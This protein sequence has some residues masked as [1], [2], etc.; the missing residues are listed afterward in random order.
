[1]PSVYQLSCSYWL[2]NDSP[3]EERLAF[4]IESGDYFPYLASVIGLLK[5]AARTCNAIPEAHGAFIEDIQEDLLHLQERYDIVP[6]E[7]PLSY[8]RKKM[9]RF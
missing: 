3:R 7:T 1:M 2:F 9:L 6:K 5:D 8:T 4:H